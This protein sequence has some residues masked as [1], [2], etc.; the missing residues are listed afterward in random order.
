MTGKSNLPQGGMGVLCLRCTGAQGG[1]ASF[2][3][4]VCGGRRGS[5]SLCV[6]VCGEKRVGRFHWANDLEVVLE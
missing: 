3:V 4:E 5:G 2:G 1:M 6:E